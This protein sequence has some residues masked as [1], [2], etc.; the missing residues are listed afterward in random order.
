MKKKLC[1]RLVILSGLILM[2]QPNF[3]QASEGESSLTIT[4]L[5]E[6]N[7]RIY[8]VSDLDFGIQDQNATK[9]NFQATD[10][11]VIKIFDRRLIEGAWTLQVKPGIFENQQGQQLTDVDLTV[12]EG[13]LTAEDASGIQPHNLLIENDG[14]DYQSIL[15]SDADHSRGWAEYRVPKEKISLALSIKEASGEY[16]ATNYWRIINAD[17]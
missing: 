14:E 2:I 6:K 12:G 8:E 5:D 15:T 17:T 1:F 10:D 16:T 7:P 3:V 9:V 11:L 4:P 13:I